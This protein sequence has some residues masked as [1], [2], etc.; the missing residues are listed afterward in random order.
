[1]DYTATSESEIH[2]QL[3]L[4]ENFKDY[5][6]ENTFTDLLVFEDEIAK[7]SSLIVLFLE[8]PGSLV[9]LGMFSCRPEFYK[10]LLI[11]APAKET[12]SEDSFIYLGPLEYIRKKE[13]NSVITYEWPTGENLDRALLIDLCE[14]I[15]NK[16]SKS[17]DTASFDED[18]SA[19][20]ALLLLEII[21]LSYPVL[22]TEMERVLEVLGLTQHSH[23]TKRCLYLLEKLGRVKKYKFGNVDYYYPLHKS[24]KTLKWGKTKDNKTVETNNIIVALKSSFILSD[25][26]SATKRKSVLEKINALMGAGGDA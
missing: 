24:E 20:I 13:E 9:E 23:Q 5:F 25:S 3:V 17:N 4:A 19:H 22:I 21:R 12:A 2:D 16:L 8:S 14:N 11:V 18:N 10:K 15:K 26:S 1:M 7:I 6:R